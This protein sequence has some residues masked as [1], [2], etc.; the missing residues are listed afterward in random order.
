MTAKDPDAVYACINYDDASC[1]EL[2]EDRAILIEGDI[3]AVLDDLSG[4]NE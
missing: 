4:G 1:P 2:I 3:G